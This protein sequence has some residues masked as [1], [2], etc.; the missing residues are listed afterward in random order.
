MWAGIH[1]F[2]NS[3]LTKVYGVVS[4]GKILYITLLAQLPLHGIFYY[5][6]G[7][8]VS[9]LYVICVIILSIFF[10]YRIKWNMRC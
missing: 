1:A 10:S 6:L 3:I 9:N 5:K 8:S 4:F 2:V 7:Y